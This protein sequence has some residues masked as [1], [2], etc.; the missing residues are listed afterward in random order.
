MAQALGLAGRGTVAEG[1]AAD[2][3]V[4]DSLSVTDALDVRGAGS[5]G[6]GDEVGGGE[7][8]GGRGRREADHRDGGTG[9]R[10]GASLTQAGPSTGAPAARVRRGLSVLLL[11][12]V[13]PC[14]RAAGAQVPLFYRLG[15]G[16]NPPGIDWRRLETAHFS[17]IYPDSLVGEAQRAASLLERAYVPLSRDFGRRPP[18]IPLVLNDQS[19][20]SNAFVAWGPRRSQW[21][22]LPPSD[23]QTFGPVD[24]Y[25]LLAVHEGRHVVQERAVRTGIPGLA[26][27]LFGDNTT[28]FVAGGLYFPPWFWEGDAVGTET[29]LSQ[30]GRGRQPSFTARVRALLLAGEPYPYEQ[31][32][33]GSFRTYYPDWYVLGYV[34]TTHVRRVYGD[35]AWREVVRRAA[36]WPI[37][38]TALSHALKAVTGRSLV[39]LQRD[40]VAALDSLWREQRSLVHETPA[41]ILS[42]VDPDYHSWSTPQYAGDGSIIALYWDQ[43]TV[44]QLVRLRPDGRRE[45]LVPR[46]GVIGDAQ[47]HVAGDR[48]VWTEYA[49]DARW[50]QRNWLVLKRLDLATGKVTQLTERSRYLGPSLSP[51]GAR[52]A[53][54][55]FSLSSRATL[56]VLDAGTG[57]ELQRLPNPAGHSLVTPAWAPDGHSLF[58]VAVDRS[59]GNALVRVRLDGTAPDTLVPFTHDAIV[60]P[61][62]QGGVVWFGSPHGGLDA[63]YAADTTTRAV[64]RVV[65]RGLGAYWPSASAD[66]TRLL[67][68]DYSV[69]GFDVAEASTDSLVFEPLELVPQHR[70]DFAAPLVHQEGG[71]TTLA[72]TAAPVAA[73]SHPFRGWGRLFDFHSLTLAPTADAW[74]RGVALESRNLLNTVGLSV[75]GTVDLDEGTGAFEAG[76]AGPACR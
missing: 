7:R 59:R 69:R 73:T 66:G 44:Q 41:R 60:R 56:V 20:I 28:A 24:W 62:P 4:L 61:A 53:A 58:V 11:L 71:D 9:A 74:N 67:F 29:A 38:P 10:P 27:R 55:D 76:E 1:A 39:Q 2:L 52:V 68:A 34:L 65:T 46:V 49:V 6:R 8:R 13:C 72:A 16:Q 3:I 57:R 50:G 43:G 35:S 48:V 51:D 31:A 37:P 36:R 22:A 40:A 14:P 21:Y 33:H 18:R 12:A 19:M 15:S 32:W 5:T 63:V 70:V 45:T 17:I 54:I 42:P 30:D 23:P 25:S 47:F 26:S 64:Y 75:G